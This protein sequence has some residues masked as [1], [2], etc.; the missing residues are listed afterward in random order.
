MILR[1]ANRR[2]VNGGDFSGDIVSI[3]SS[4]GEST[5]SGGTSPGGHSTSSAG[6][7]EKSPGEFDV[8]LVTNINSDHNRV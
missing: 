2:T 5:S 4:Q 3:P 8:K 1:V 6:M 7:D